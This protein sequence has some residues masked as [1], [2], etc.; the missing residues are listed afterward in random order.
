MDGARSMHWRDTKFWAKG[1]VGKPSRG[2]EDNIRT[3]LREIL[4]EGVGWI[5]LDQDGDQWRDLVNTVMKRR[6]P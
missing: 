5:H 2:W 4:W 1:P 6:V 3:N